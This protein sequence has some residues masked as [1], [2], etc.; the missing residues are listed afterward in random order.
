MSPALDSP[1]DR[2]RLG[3][4]LGTLFVLWIAFEV[5]SFAANLSM[6]QLAPAYMFTPLVAGAVTLLR[7]DLGV[8]DVGLRV[9]RVR[10]LAVAAILPLLTAGAIVGV[11]IAVPGIAFSQGATLLP[12]ADLPGGVLGA[13][14]VGA[15][16]L[17]L[18]VTVNAVFAIGE[19]IG[20]RGYLLW[21]LAP[22]GFWRASAVIGLFWGVWHAPV[23]VEGY[24]YPSFPL[25][26][27]AVM[28]GA[29]L[30]FSFV[31]TYLVLRAESLVAAF[32]FHGVFNASAG[33]VLAY[34]AAESAALS[35][36]VASSIGV[37]GMVAFLLLAGGIALLDPPELHRETLFGGS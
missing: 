18:G 30:T 3:T 25:V 2:T 23:I 4:F 28:T 14:A 12:W 22:L 15:I 29:T 24:N 27:V 5:V 6:V 20:W 26:G 35:Q 19:E 9:G 1:I 34:T 16:I 31:Y 8:R 36:L 7:S 11:S 13:V 17:G 33:L 32:F 10:W 37:A 21:E